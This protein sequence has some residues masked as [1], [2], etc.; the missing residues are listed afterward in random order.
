MQVCCLL[1]IC[2]IIMVTW[3]PDSRWWTSYIKVHTACHWNEFIL[4]TFKYMIGLYIFPLQ[5][6]NGSYFYKPM[7]ILYY[8][9][10]I[11]YNKYSRVSL[12]EL[13]TLSEQLTSPQI[14]WWVYFFSIFSFLCNVLWIIVCPFA[15]GHC[16]VCPSIYRFWLPLWYL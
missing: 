7:K 4:S 15:L 12:V 3:S 8:Q 1:F 14:F 6:I 5:Y 11:L 9:D 10:K 13:L 16:A 2:K